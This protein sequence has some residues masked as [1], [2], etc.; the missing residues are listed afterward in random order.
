MF[1]LG[2]TP[3]RYVWS[4]RVALVQSRF[5]EN[6]GVRITVQ[7]STRHLKLSPRQ[8]WNKSEGAILTN[9][10]PASEVSTASILSSIRALSFYA[11]SQTLSATSEKF[12]QIRSRTARLGK[13]TRRGIYAFVL[14]IGGSCRFY[15][16][17]SDTV[18]LTGRKRFL[19]YDAERAEE[20]G[21]S[22][23]RYLLSQVSYTAIVRKHT[24]NNLLAYWALCYTRTLVS[25][26]IRKM[27]SHL[28]QEVSNFHCQQRNKRRLRTDDPVTQGVQELFDKLFL[29]NHVRDISLKLYV[30]DDFGKIWW[31]LQTFFIANQIHKRIKMHMH[32]LAWIGE[33]FSSTLGVF[34]SANQLMSLLAFLHTS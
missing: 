16:R 2:R 5:V 33:G 12:A 7:S 8:Y 11:L 10:G 17:H 25:Y 29:G 3:L 23:M 20:I 9:T 27:H 19:W 34:Y 4:A 6:P 21:H 13:W 31:S 22:Q 18:P 24:P 28:S 1:R 26:T 15:V 32:S 14:L 30:F